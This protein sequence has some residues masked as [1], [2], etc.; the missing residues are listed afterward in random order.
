MST[1]A[2]NAKEGVY[3]GVGKLAGFGNPTA[4]VRLPSCSQ[5]LS[6]RLVWVGDDTRIRIYHLD[7]HR[8]TTLAAKIPSWIEGMAVNAVGLLHVATI[9]HC[10][11]TVSDR[12][13][14]KLLC[15][16][17]H[18][19]AFVDGAAAEACFN[20]PSGIAFDSIHRLLVAFVMSLPFSFSVV[21]LILT[22]LRRC[23]TMAT[24]AFDA[25]R[26]MVSP[27]RSRV[28]VS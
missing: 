20:F 21:A 12:N 7:E 1:V 13:E 26:L 18:K 27:A 23:A 19:R 5:S 17:P 3:D 11:Y 28:V 15:G 16:E 8:V 9:N 14:V 22:R 6:S 10:I 25:S 2:G 4:M 24:V